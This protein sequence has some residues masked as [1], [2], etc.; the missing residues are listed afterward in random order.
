MNRGLR[1][2]L[3]ALV[4]TVVVVGAWVGAP[5]M[6]APA[7]PLGL[8]GSPGIA[9]AGVAPSPVPSIAGP[10]ASTIASPTSVSPPRISPSPGTA[11][12]RV[13]ASNLGGAPSPAASTLHRPASATPLLLAALDSRLERLRAKY[14]IPGISASI[15]FADGSAWHGAAGLADVV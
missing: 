15:L 1:R 4:V 14:G 6:A 13:P 7:D 2:P 12:T 9:V 11:A 3:I 10:S 8:D 5:L